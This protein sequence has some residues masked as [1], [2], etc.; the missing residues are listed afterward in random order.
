MFNTYIVS[1]DPL[2]IDPSPL[3]F[4]EYVRGHALTYQFYS[5]FAGTLYV[6]SPATLGN[7]IN[8]YRNFL[9]PNAWT[10]ALLREPTINS[11]GAANS[12]FWAW[13]NSPVPPPLENQN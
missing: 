1:Y 5:A 12:E 8:S 13:L 3:R 10:I 6:K 9:Q 2:M 11:G 4:I 7:L